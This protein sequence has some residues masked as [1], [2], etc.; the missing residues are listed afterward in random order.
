MS[1]GLTFLGDIIVAACSFAAAW[2]FKDKIK[3]AVSAALAV[4]KAKS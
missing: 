4:F 3:A 2:I 1:F